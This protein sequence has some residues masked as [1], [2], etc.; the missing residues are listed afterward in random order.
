[1]MTELST[2][3]ASTAVD[4]GLAAAVAVLQVLTN[5]LYFKGVWEYPFE[6]R[7]TRAQAFAAVT[8]DS[9]AKVGG[10]V[11]LASVK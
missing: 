9:T 11:Q 3:W 4:H 10:D 8:K 7:R 2:T 5:A 1:M 6:K